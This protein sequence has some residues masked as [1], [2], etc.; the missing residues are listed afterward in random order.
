VDFVEATSGHVLVTTHEEHVR[1]VCD[2]DVVFASRHGVVGE[3]LPSLPVF[4]S[5]DIGQDVV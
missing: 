2:R 4:G 5:P 3:L 1:T